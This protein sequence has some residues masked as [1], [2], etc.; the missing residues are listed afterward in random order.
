MGKGL[1]TVVGGGGADANAAT[2][3]LHTRHLFCPTCGD[4]LRVNEKDKRAQCLTCS[5][6]CGV[7]AFL[8]VTIV[9]ESGPRDWQ[10]KYGVQPIIKENPELEKSVEQKRQVVDDDCPKCGHKGLEFY[11]LQL[12]SADEGQTVFYE[13]PSCGHKFSQN[14]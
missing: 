8:N 2:S 10:K 7:D 3:E 9:S 5:F 6:A 12:R 4:L 13:C 14:T 1:Q 11:T